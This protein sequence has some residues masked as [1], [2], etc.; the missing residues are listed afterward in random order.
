MSDILINGT[1]A[2]NGAFP[3]ARS[4]NL[5][6]TSVV[7]GATTD[8]ALATL[9]NQ[10]GVSAGSPV[11][12]FLDDTHIIPTGTQNSNEVN[13]L[14]KTPITTTEVLDSIVVNNNTLLKEV[15][16]Y[17]T[18]LSGTQIEGGVWQFDLWRQV[19]VT[20]GVSEILINMMQAVA[21]PIGTVTMTGT[22]TSRT[23]TVSGTTAFKAADADSDITIASY[24][25]TPTGFF[26]ITGF[27][28]LTQVTIATPSTYV[29]E[30]TVVFSKH[31]KLFQVTTGDINNTGLTLQ[32]IT[33]VQPA[34]PISAGD[35]LS[36]IY[37]G[38]TTDTSNVTISY[39]HNGNARYTH[40]SSPLVIR[41]NDLAGLGISSPTEPYGHIS[42]GALTN[43]T[44]ATTQSQGDNSTKVATTAYVDAFTVT[45]DAFPSDTLYVRQFGSDKAEVHYPAGT[46]GTGFINV[47]ADFPASGTPVNGDCYTVPDGVTVT[48]NNPAKTNTGQTFVGPIQIA[49]NS[50]DTKW[51]ER[52]GLTIDTCVSSIST[53][54][55]LASFLSNIPIYVLDNATYTFGDDQV[56]YSS[57]I[58]P[59]AKLR[60]LGYV[61]SYCP[62]VL[63]DTLEIN[64]TGS[65][66]GWLN[67]GFT[68][69]FIING[70]YAYMNGTPAPIGIFLNNGTGKLFLNIGEINGL[71]PSNQTLSAQGAPIYAN[72]GK[73]TG[74]ATVTMAG[75][76]ITL[77]TLDRT[78]LTK[79]DTLGTIL[80]TA[81]TSD[82]IAP[83]VERVD[84]TTPYGNHF[85]RPITTTDGLI[86][87]GAHI[88]DRSNGYYLGFNLGYTL[89]SGK[90][91]QQS[92]DNGFLNVNDGNHR[93][94]VQLN[95]AS[96]TQTILIKDG[97]SPQNI[98]GSFAADL[99]QTWR[100]EVPF[101]LNGGIQ[102]PFVTTTINIGDVSNTTFNTTN[103]TVV[104]AVNEVYSIAT[105]G[106][107]A[108][109][110]TIWK[111]NPEGENFYFDQSVIQATGSENSVQLNELTSDLSGSS[112]YDA[113]IAVD[114]V[115]PVLHA[116]FIPSDSMSYMAGFKSGVTAAKIYAK[117][118]SAAAN[119][120]IQINGMQYHTYTGLTISVT[121][122]G[123]NRNAIASGNAF[124]AGDANVDPTIASYLETPKGRYRILGYINA[125][126]VVILVPAGYT[127]ETS[128]AF[129]KYSKLYSMV[130][131]N[132]VST[133]TLQPITCFSSAQLE[134]SPDSTWSWSQLSNSDKISFWVFGVTDS[135]PSLTITF[136]YN[137]TTNYSH[138]ETPKLLRIKS[139]TSGSLGGGVLNNIREQQLNTS[140]GS[141][142]FISVPDDMK[143]LLSAY[144]EAFSASGYSSTINRYTYY[145]DGQGQNN[146]QYTASVLAEPLSLTANIIS[147]ISF[148][149]I[150]A[151]AIGGTTGTIKVF[152]NSISQVFQITRI[153]FQYI[154]F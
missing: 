35:K 124:V 10:I 24:L 117:V 125:T 36:T 72:V 142:F 145:C 9:N 85:V 62:S 48:D 65:D 149:D 64:T 93:T 15:Y 18:A 6:N 5:E 47:A 17:N 82:I 29:N 136:A 97:D 71:S 140:S 112:E 46:T 27:T 57:I 132:I 37:F 115:T 14:S 44:T 25:Q 80:I 127:N 84:L 67:G 38:T 91:Y 68:N 13:T 146:N 31:Q 94:R 58:A 154:P 55:Y 63:F 108:V 81:N 141:S 135:A 69:D 60:C 40:F 95:A 41:H 150:F 118:S 105:S 96:A 110:Q 1:L 102:D 99:T 148:N 87:S 11:S 89:D 126:E 153:V 144:V 78:N 50:G 7:A 54:A 122:T 19:S 104:G 61:F 83:V 88:G 152:N 76:E 90:F 101:K 137:G 30:T 131:G 134:N 2:P 119:T 107:P 73:F 113:T 130:S 139:S 23:A 16:L 138:V 120:Y 49:W 42:N 92:G 53:A 43:G 79:N 86:S 32:T 70:K 133:S 56:L 21:F 106:T 26:Q 103:K 33:T 52:N 34:F 128:V 3:L 28:S 59:S 111:I 109:N 121:G 151:N 147:K 98:V 45:Q 143:T 22:G 75:G 51:I 8:D 77:N 116:A 100:C 123:S 74:E 20:T 66:G 4:A 12:F 114:S 39:T 129:S